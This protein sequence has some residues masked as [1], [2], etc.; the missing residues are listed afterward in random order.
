MAYAAAQM[1]AVKCT[2]AHGGRS[3]VERLYGLDFLSP[4]VLTEPQRSVPLNT[5]H[6]PAGWSRLSTPSSELAPGARLGCRARG[7]SRKEVTYE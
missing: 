2:T 6:R 7:W 1:L 4:Q 3:R 5:R